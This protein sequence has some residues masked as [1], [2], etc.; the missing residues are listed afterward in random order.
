VFSRLRALFFERPRKVP[1][2]RENTFSLEKAS[3]FQRD[4]KNVT[5]TY[6]LRDT[7]NPDNKSFDFLIL[8]YTFVTAA[9]CA[10]FFDRKSTSLLNDDIGRVWTCEHVTLR[11]KRESRNEV[12]QRHRAA[13]SSRQC[14]KS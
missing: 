14:L 7:I 4:R 8:L 2:G 10:F 13:D 1:L 5:M 9:G 11:F 3:G 12:S 6:S